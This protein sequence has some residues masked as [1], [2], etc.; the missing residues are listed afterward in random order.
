MYVDDWLRKMKLK[1]ICFRDG[2]E[3][4]TDLLPIILG[5]ISVLVILCI[6]ACLYVWTQKRKKSDKKNIQ[7]NYDL[8]KNCILEKYA[9]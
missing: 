2:K 7:G 6:T 9:P 4:T 5:V 8:L 1:F 3:E